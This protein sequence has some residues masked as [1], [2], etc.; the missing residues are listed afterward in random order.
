MY[1]TLA[2][3][4][5]IVK[6]IWTLLEY[7]F[8]TWVLGIPCSYPGDAI[9]NPLKRKGK[10][11]NHVSV[12]SGGFKFSCDAESHKISQKSA[13]KYKMTGE[14]AGRQIWYYKEGDEASADYAFCA[15]QNPNSADKPFRAAMLEKWEGTRPDVNST[16]ADAFS[17]AVKGLEFYQMLQ[18]DDG[19]WAGDYGGPMFLMPGIITTLYIT[20]APFPQWRKEAMTKYLVNHQQE[21]GAL[22]LFQLLILL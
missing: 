7:L 8:N 12:S 5:S 18:C 11:S 2:Y 16:P 6:A 15:S 21:G 13:P 3:V 10:W 20:K 9:K 22:L 1:S 17:A 4:K 14:S 19:H